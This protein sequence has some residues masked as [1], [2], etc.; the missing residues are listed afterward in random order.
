M[1]K[2]ILSFSIPLFTFLVII[3]LASCTKEV[4]RL[5]FQ[6]DEL[7]TAEE[8]VVLAKKLDVDKFNY[9]RNV[10]AE[11]QYKVFL[12]RVL[13]YDNQMSADKSV[14]CESCHKQELAFADNVAFSRG[15][16]GNHTDRNSIALASFSS[17]EG[18]YGEGDPTDV[19]AN[20]LF[21]D[22]RVDNVSAQLSETFANPN[23]MGMKLH[24]LGARVGDLDY[25]KLLYDKAFPG[26][27]LTS[28]N[29]IAAIAAFVGQ[30]ESLNS[31][32]D[33]GL[34][35]SFFEVEESF[36][37]FSDAQN[38]GKQLF[39]TNCA[40]CHAFS[41]SESFRHQFGNNDQLASNGLDVAY[42]DKGLGR[43]TSLVKDNGI[44]KIP[45]VRNV[46]L[47][48]P[49]MHDGRFESLEEVVDF[50]S[51]NIQAHPNL[52]DKLKDEN[53]DPIRMNFTDT[54]K[55]D[56]VAFLNAL[57]GSTHMESDLATPFK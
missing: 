8:K 42:E 45:G 12:G 35:A 9:I 38:N 36:A 3:L 49:Y 6:A 53:G 43:H 24:E 31:T 11:E 5:P 18:H 55:A 57:T 25:A 44:F 46:E 4:E 37:E 23:E 26:Q 39:L 54:E 47:T 56:L 14:S 7:F 13:F 27:N 40:S 2:N 21:W 32:F 48:A 30:I 10:T 41:L 15:V 16:S 17:F 20:S 19:A 51:E 33:K 22:G 29:V 1:K 34:N 52:S 50:Y 28:A